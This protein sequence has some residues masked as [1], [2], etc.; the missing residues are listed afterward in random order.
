MEGLFGDIHQLKQEK[1]PLQTK[2]DY[3]YKTNNNLMADYNASKI[4]IKKMED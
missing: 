4:N 1:V 3:Y 2:L